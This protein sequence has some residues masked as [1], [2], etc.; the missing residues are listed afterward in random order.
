MQA[1]S[2]KRRDR[3]ATALQ[4]RL[5]CARAYDRTR[6]H[7]ADEIPGEDQVGGRNSGLVD[8]EAG[9]VGE[10]SAPTVELWPPDR[11][12]VVGRDVRHLSEAVAL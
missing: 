2:Y 11:R 8:I 12:A 6:T 1:F 3:A 10:R 7:A 9:H 5:F 4:N